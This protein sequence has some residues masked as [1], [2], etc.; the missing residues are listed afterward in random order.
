M[1]ETGLEPPPKSSD[2]STVSATGDAECGALG[3]RTGRIDG[4]LQTVIDA[5]PDL[6][7][8]VRADILAMLTAAG[9][10]GEG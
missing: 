6:P 2:I 9:S 5:W 10:G 4:D 7:E 3:A 8:A 1:A